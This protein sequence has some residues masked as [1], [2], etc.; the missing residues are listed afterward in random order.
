MFQRS[1]I[2]KRREREKDRKEIV[3]YVQQKIHLFLYTV[4]I[5][6]RKYTQ[7]EIFYMEYIKAYRIHR[8][9]LKACLEHLFFFSFS[10]DM[11]MKVFIQ[12]NKMLRERMM[13]DAYKLTHLLT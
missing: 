5:F 6:K 3:C 4:I 8:N 9:L 2:C 1:Y 11:R 7:F 10:S 12:M 13:I